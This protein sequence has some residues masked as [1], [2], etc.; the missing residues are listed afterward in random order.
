MIGFGSSKKLIRIINDY[1]SFET[2]TS[3]R[4]ARGWFIISWALVSQSL[5]AYHQWTHLECSFMDKSKNWAFGSGYSCTRP[6]YHY[7]WLKFMIE[8]A[9]EVYVSIIV[10]LLVPFSKALF[11]GGALNPLTW[12]NYVLLWGAVYFSVYTLA[13]GN[14]AQLINFAMLLLKFLPSTWQTWAN[15]F[16]AA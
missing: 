5:F 7:I 9:S 6:E 12:I 4:R 2:G 8:F 15:S 13:G 11:G 16:V 10:A 1:K 3:L 14:V